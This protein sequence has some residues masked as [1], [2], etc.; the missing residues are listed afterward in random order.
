MEHVYEDVSE[1]LENCP[2]MST[3]PKNSVNQN[4]SGEENLMSIQV[5]P[6]IPNFSVNSTAQIIKNNSE[7]SITTTKDFTESILT[8]SQKTENK[9]SANPQHITVHNTGKFTILIFLFI[10]LLVLAGQN[11]LL[12]NLNKNYQSFKKNQSTSTKSHF[13]KLLDNC[14]KKNQ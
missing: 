2:A 6:I 7:F 8:N 11:S 10:L 12:S 13:K 1:W 14:N 4:L 5:V 9:E 3:P